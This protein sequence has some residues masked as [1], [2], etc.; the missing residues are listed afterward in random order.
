MHACTW[1]HVRALIHRHTC[2]AH[3]HMRIYMHDA[4][5]LHIHVKTLMCAHTLMHAHMLAYMHIY[6]CSCTRSR[7]HKHTRTCTY[8]CM[9]TCTRTCPCPCTLYVFRACCCACVCVSVYHP[10]TDRS[11]PFPLR[12]MLI[13]GIIPRLF[14]CEC[15]ML[16]VWCEMRPCIEEGMT[17]RQVEREKETE[18]EDDGEWEDARQA[19]R[20]NCDMKDMHQ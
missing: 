16:L 8:T 15:D 9:M 3:P 1:T 10:V 7:T 6:T 14:G 2:N 18:E 5:R 4:M 17:M 19:H 11:I 12:H 20:A 13:R